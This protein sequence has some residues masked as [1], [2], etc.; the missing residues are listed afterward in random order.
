VASLDP[1]GVDREIGAG[2]RRL[3]GKKPVHPKATMCEYQVGRK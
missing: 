3:G 2:M 1:P